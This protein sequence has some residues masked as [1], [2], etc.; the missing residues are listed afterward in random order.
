MAV[1]ATPRTLPGGATAHLSTPRGDVASVASGESCHTG[2]GPSPGRGPANR[3]DVAHRT[4]CNH[5]GA[6]ACAYAHSLC[7]AVLQLGVGPHRAVRVVSRTP[8]GSAEHP[9]EAR[10]CAQVPSDG[11]Q[12]GGDVLAGG[13]G[14]DGRQVPAGVHGR[15]PATVNVLWSRAPR[16]PSPIAARERRRGID[17]RGAQ[18]RPGTTSAPAREPRL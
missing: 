18:T 5:P 8:P 11:Q 17:P 2:A 13:Q 7:P 14:A 3:R 4:G 6:T 10:P 9:G 12:L 15:L 16:D 1:R